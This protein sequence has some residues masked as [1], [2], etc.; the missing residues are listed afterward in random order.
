M[1]SPRV[2][3]LAARLEKGRKKSFEI[4]NAITPEQWQVPLY[5]QPEW[6]VHHLLAHF[7]SSE[8]QLR[9]LI[10]DVASGGMGAPPDLDL[11]S[12]NASEQTRL[13][14]RSVLEL[15]D[16]LET[17]RQQT[18]EWVRTLDDD[19][20]DKIGRHPALGLVN[21]ET[22]ITAIY[23]HQLMHMRDLSRLAAS[24]V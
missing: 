4:F 22:M 15:L 3:A 17:E 9:L 19:Q 11:D 21:V 18:L 20:L 23:G 10:Q 12:Y 16:M 1:T 13:E 2:E 8:S 24:I 5:L 14:G 6:R 7:V